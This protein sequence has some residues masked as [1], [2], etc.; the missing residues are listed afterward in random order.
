MENLIE[1]I[2]K[3]FKEECDYIKE[4][5]KLQIYK[6]VLANDINYHV[7]TVHT[8]YS[9]KR[10]L[11]MEYTK[12]IPIDKFCDGPVPQDLRNRIGELLLRLV[13]KEIFIF[14]FMQ[15]DPNPANFFYDTEKSQLVLIDLGA[16]RMFD[17]EF[18]DNYV[19]L[20]YAATNR[21]KKGI[22]KFAKKINVLTG[23][24]NKRVLDS[25]IKLS[26]ALGEPFNEETAP[27]YDFSTQEA[28][29]KIYKLMPEMISSRLTPLPSETIPLNRK[30]SGNVKNYYRCLLT[31]NK[32]KS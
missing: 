3:E 26:L 17:K 23:E 19:Q 30:L 24:E 2:R 15:S 4:A 5:H 13:L 29:E 16:G 25:Y 20:V 28:T 31:T 14:R 12:G 1:T 10:C 18:I 8:K 32:I 21:D 7:P 22:L 9:N 11:C 6:D 27:Y